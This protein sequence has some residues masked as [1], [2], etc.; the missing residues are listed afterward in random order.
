[1][2]EKTESVKSK[3]ASLCTFRTPL[4]RRVCVRSGA[5]SPA[6]NGT[7]FNRIALFKSFGN[8][9]EIAITSLSTASSSTDPQQR[10]SKCLKPKRENCRKKITP[11]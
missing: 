1:M 10:F 2:E 5:L 4:Y 3:L 8:E 9:L 7:A 11:N 6:V